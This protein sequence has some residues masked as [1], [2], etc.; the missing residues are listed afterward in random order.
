MI[1]LARKSQRGRQELRRRILQLPGRSIRQRQAALDFLRVRLLYATL[2]LQRA[3]HAA[4]DSIKAEAFHRRDIFTK[5]THSRLSQ[6]HPARARMDA[7]GIMT[8]AREAFRTSI[9]LHGQRG[10]SLK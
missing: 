9:R 7:D 10:P 3:S 2:C 5:Q 8:T 6:P 1:T 4:P